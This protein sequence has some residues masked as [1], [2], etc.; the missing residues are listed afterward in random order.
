MAGKQGS[1]VGPALGDA[2]AIRFDSGSVFNIEIHNIQGSGVAPPAAAT[3]YA[4]PAAVS[5]PASS[6][7]DEDLLFQPGERVTIT[8]P[9]AM[10]GK[11]GSVVGPALGDAFAIRFDSGSVFNIEIHNI[12]GSGVPAPAPVAAAP[13]YA[14]P[15]AVAAPAASGDDE[16][17]EFQP[18]QKVEI[19]GPPAMAGKR[20][21]VI[22][23]AL[24]SAFSVRFESG[25]VFNIETGNLR[26]LAMAM[27]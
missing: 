20:G 1:V 9:P 15:T 25:S 12:Q 16:E 23:S 6:G 2:F 19:L 14:A 3:S 17:L 4:A 13:S 7:D 10:A 8:G 21:E 24:N 22:G 11:Q 27:A 5:A 18:G 26:A